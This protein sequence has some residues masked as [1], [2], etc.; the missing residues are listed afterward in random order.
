VDEVERTISPGATSGGELGLVNL[1]GCASLAEKRVLRNVH[2]KDVLV[3][4]G[5]LHSRRMYMTKTG[6]PKCVRVGRTEVGLVSLVRGCNGVEVVLTFLQGGG[7]AD[8]V[9]AANGATLFVENNCVPL[10][11]QLTDG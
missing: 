11:R 3:V 7:G 5:V 4:G 2:T 9:P 8:K 10:G 6:V 1:G